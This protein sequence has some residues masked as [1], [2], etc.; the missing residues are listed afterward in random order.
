[1]EVENSLAYSLFLLNDGKIGS[2]EEIRWVIKERTLF[3]KI[4]L[5]NRMKT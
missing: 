2:E 4:L 5:Q 1:M 3:R